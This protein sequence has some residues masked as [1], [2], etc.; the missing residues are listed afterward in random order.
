[1]CVWTD[2]GL[3]QLT[4]ADLSRKVKL[5]SFLPHS[6]L[7]NGKNLPLDRSVVDPGYDGPAGYRTASGLQ[8]CLKDGHS[9]NSS[10]VEYAAES[11]DVYPNA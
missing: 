9:L 6:V 7:V 3:G 8:D 5:L 10:G 11:S 1:M 2:R 4:A